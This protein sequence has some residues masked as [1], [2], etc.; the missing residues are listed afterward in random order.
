TLVNQS[1]DM[2]LRVF[3]VASGYQRGGDAHAPEVDGHF[4]TPASVAACPEGTTLLAAYRHGGL[5][6][7]QTRG[8]WLQ[9]TPAANPRTGQAATTPR[10]VTFT[11]MAYS[12]TDHH[13]AVCCGERYGRLVDPS[14]GQV[15]G[16]PL[17]ND[18]SFPTF[19]PD[20]RLLATAAFSH[21]TGQPPWIR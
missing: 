11:A 10:H 15:L 9:A 13:V 2:R 6:V 3:D 18:L 17:A 8:C 5:R 16:Q 14:T 1:V 7:W 19:S 12:P 21:G 4:P 20:G